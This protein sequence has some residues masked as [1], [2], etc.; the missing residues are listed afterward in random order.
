MSWQEAQV[1][2]FLFSSK[3]PTGLLQKSVMQP[4]SPVLTGVCHKAPDSPGSPHLS[5]P[6][7]PPDIND[8]HGA[9]PPMSGMGI[10]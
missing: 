1:D 3:Y 7:Y 8:W 2:F 9:H 10:L 4:T 6:F 5:V